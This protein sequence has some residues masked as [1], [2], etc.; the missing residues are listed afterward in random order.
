M[1]DYQR[2]D[3]L[4]LAHKFDPAK[5]DLKSTSHW[6]LSEKLDG[7]RVFWDG[8]VSRGE[9]KASIP[10]ANTAKDD[11]YQQQQKATGLWT[12]LGNVIHAPSWFLDQLPCMTLDGELYSDRKSWQTIASTVKTL[13]PDDLA[14]ESIRLH[15]FDIPPVSQVFLDGRITN[16]HFDLIIDRAECMQRYMEL[17]KRMGTQVLFFNKFMDFNTINVV[18]KT[19]DTNQ[20]VVP[21]EQIP[22]TEQDDVYSH[23]DRITDLGG[24]GIMLRNGKSYWEPK[25]SYQLLKVKKRLDAEATVI[26]YVWGRATDRGSKLLGLMG[27]LVVNFKGRRLELS[28]F[29]DSERVM[30]PLSRES[31]L[32]ESQFAQGLMVSCFWTNKQFPIGSQVTFRYRELSNDGIPKE[33]AYWRKH[34]PA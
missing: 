32:G 13:V 20:I 5:H 29:T 18:L 1:S 10:W 4:M 26:G 17:S 21:I 12:R 34:E 3:F 6:Y 31:D 2:R 14:W 22:I 9:L 15:A 19:I 25:R 33:A 23:L 16:P 8:G 28:G 30:S 11:R 7:I 27:A 24:E